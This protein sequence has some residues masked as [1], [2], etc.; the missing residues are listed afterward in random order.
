MASTNH[1]P[2]KVLAFNANYIVR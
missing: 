1:T 2:I